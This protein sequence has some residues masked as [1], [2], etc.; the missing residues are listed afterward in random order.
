M[1]PMF[2]GGSTKPDVG[3]PN[4]VAPQDSVR[5]TTRGDAGSMDTLPE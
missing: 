3:A 2:D 5:P 4:G 1:V